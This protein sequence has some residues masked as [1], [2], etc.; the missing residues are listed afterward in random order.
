MKKKLA[1][2]LVLMV[3]MLFAHVA[4]ACIYIQPTGSAGNQ[5]NPPTGYITGIASNGT[6][7]PIL[8][9]AYAGSIFT[10]ITFDNGSDPDVGFTGSWVGTKITQFSISAT[11]V[12]G[13][14]VA[15]WNINN[16]NGIIKSV[17]F[18]MFTGQLY[19]GGVDKGMTGISGLG[20]GQRKIA[21]YGVQDG[22]S[23]VFMPGTIPS[24]GCTFDVDD[25]GAVGLA[26]MPYEKSKLEWWQL[27]H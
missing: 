24:T 6:N 17:G 10:N 5:N 1:A 19:S 15:S 22:V 7:I 13:K 16:V 4:S 12:G 26:L 21:F 14:T 23:K 8:T 11:I 27:F 25:L 9:V 20:L 3:S 18:A 2:A